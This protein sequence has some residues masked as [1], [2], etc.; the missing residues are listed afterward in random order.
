MWLGSILDG[1][2][3]LY[4][5]PDQTSETERL[6]LRQI[7]ID[8][9]HFADQ[10]HVL[11]S[12]FYYLPHPQPGTTF[13][14]LMFMDIRMGLASF[15]FVPRPD[16]DLDEGN[17]IGNENMEIIGERGVFIYNI[18][19]HREPIFDWM[20]WE[21]DRTDTFKWYFIDL[22]CNY[23]KEKMA[24]SKVELE[25]LRAIAQTV[26]NG[27]SDPLFTEMVAELRNKADTYQ[28]LQIW[29]DFLNLLHYLSYLWAVNPMWLLAKLAPGDL[30]TDFIRLVQFLIPKIEVELRIKD[31]A[32]SLNELIK[33]IDAFIAEMHRKAP[34]LGRLSWL[35]ITILS[36]QQIA[37]AVIGI[38]ED[39]L[40]NI[41]TL[42]MT[43]REDQKSIRHLL[44]IR[45][46]RIMSIP[47]IIAAVEETEKDRISN[48][49]SY[50][51]A[52]FRLKEEAATYP[53]VLG[54][55]SIIFSVFCPPLGACLGIFSAVVSVDEA[56]FKTLL[57]NADANPD[58]CFVSQA[59]AREARFWAA[60]D[61]LFACFDIVEL[62]GVFRTVSSMKDAGVLSRLP[63]NIEEIA[64]AGADTTRNTA[65][66][67]R[68]TEAADAAAI[69]RAATEVPVDEVRQ[70][71]FQAETG[72]VNL[73][74]NPRLETPP[75]TADEVIE[76]ASDEVKATL[77]G[78]TVDGNNIRNQI[79]TEY[80]AHFDE[81]M[82]RIHEAE[83]AGRAVPP[84]P[85]HYEVFAQ[86]RYREMVA[87]YPPKS[88]D[89]PHRNEF[90]SEMA[91]DGSSIGNLLNDTEN[92]RES[93]KTRLL[94]GSD[95]GLVHFDRRFVDDF[96]NALRRQEPDDV[97]DTLIQERFLDPI[98]SFATR[99]GFPSGAS[100]ASRE[101]GFFA[102]GIKNG[103]DWT[104]DEAFV[105]L[106]ELFEHE[107]M[108]RDVLHA[109]MNNDNYCA[110]VR[111]KIIN[112][113]LAVALNKII[114]V[115]GVRTRV[116]ANNPSLFDSLISGNRG[117]AFEPIAAA[118]IID[119]LPDAARIEVGRRFVLDAVDDWNR[120]MG[121]SMHNIL[122]ADILVVMPDGRRILIDCKFFKG[123]ISV[124]EELS[125]QLAKMAY[126]IDEGLIDNAEYWVSHHFA[127]PSDNGLSNL[128]AFQTEADMFS[129]GKI[130]IV[131]GT[132]ENGF[133]QIFADSSRYA[134]VRRGDVVLIPD[135]P[136]VGRPVSGSS[137]IPET[138]VTGAEDIVPEPVSVN[139]LPHPAPLS[140]GPPPNRV[141]LNLTNPDQRV[142]VAVRPAQPRLGFARTPE[143]GIENH[144]SQVFRTDG[145]HIP[146]QPLTTPGR[147]RLVV[148]RID[149]GVNN[150][151]DQYC[152]VRVRATTQ[153]GASFSSN[154]ITQHLSAEQMAQLVT[155]GESGEALQ[156]SPGNSVMNMP[157]GDTTSDRSFQL[158]LE[159]DWIHCLLLHR[160]DSSSDVPQLQI[161]L[162]REGG[163]QV[164]VFNE[165]NEH[166]P[167]NGPF[168][169]VPISGQTLMSPFARYLVPDH[170][171]LSVRLHING[172]AATHRRAI[173][174]EVKP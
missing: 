144:L 117:H 123:G 12:G 51:W 73:E 172:I 32:L 68:M 140:L 115:P 132:Y 111:N 53:L 14:P 98:D 101:F 153:L 10:G 157:V 22:C 118:S 99:A 34:L 87:Q 37:D 48:D 91:G 33:R 110:S 159:P 130:H 131:F 24:E 64:E 78:R 81:T 121:E 86:N 57:S 127:R 88:A 15:L 93:L 119:E 83:N 150:I 104:H 1:T 94:N 161:V 58:D 170:Y 11:R 42:E 107:D 102:V 27:G 74:A 97:L 4:D 135:H 114:E 40:S 168:T 79:D 21:P 46:P 76:N 59:E 75:G 122:E 5:S 28:K 134:E 103:S 169:A 80:R 149:D 49:V 143:P 148:S 35:Q 165:E 45:P 137:P 77:T 66:L 147:M 163:N 71:A 109:I 43:I 65:T 156:L 44:R 133:P 9:D 36:D 138:V 60:L 139:A 124:K 13:Q 69:E 18:T 164:F 116:S 62:S 136:D 90:F 84:N 55:G 89:I 70:T 82:E 19:E 160:A 106:R 17:M 30:E 31:P 56:H 85:L 47:R 126:G 174:F 154:L 100:E 105:A 25:N 173:S 50:F 23:A 155:D 141:E 7:K 2:L 8:D 3:Y 20:R 108:N 63:D 96:K 41:A 125:N 95:N 120:T 151:I 61:V 6:T 92:L 113:D 112:E 38:C 146:L 171:I 16:A 166:I 39:M 152:L 67:E 54:I 142:R 29:R 26:S 167:F 158:S 52:V 145:V 162:S 129:G 72:R 128:D